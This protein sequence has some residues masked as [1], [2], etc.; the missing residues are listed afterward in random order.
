MENVSGLGYF[1]KPSK[2]SFYGDLCSFYGTENISLII[3]IYKN[4]IRAN[5]MRFR[6]KGQSKTAIIFPFS[7]ITK[8][9]QTFLNLGNHQSLLGSATAVR[10]EREE[11]NNPGP[12]YDTFLF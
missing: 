3:D 5:R 2:C 10:L 7:L 9:K 8:A 6:A 11:R 12:V 4:N 1:H